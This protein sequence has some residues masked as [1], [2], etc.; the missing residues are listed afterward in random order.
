MNIDTEGGFYSAVIAREVAM[1]TRTGNNK[2]LSEI[3]TIKTSVDTAASSGLTTVSVSTII[4][5]DVNYFRAYNDPYN[6]G[7]GTTFDLQ[8]NVMNRVI[9]YFTRLGYDIK[10]TRVG[11]TE[12]FNWVISW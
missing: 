12:A 11:T 6:T 2:I 10:R 7:Y 5:T 4:S 8:R 3:N 1:G 9:A